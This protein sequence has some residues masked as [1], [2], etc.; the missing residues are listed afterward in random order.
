MKKIVLV[1][2]ALSIVWVSCNNTTTS[3]DSTSSSAATENGAAIAFEKNNFDFGKVAAG[4]KV[5][6]EFKFKNTGNAPLIIS[7]AQA[8]CGCTVP[9]YPKEPVAPGESGVIRVVFDSAGR[10]GMQNKIVSVTSNATP[11]L[12]EIYLTGEVTAK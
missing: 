9:E 1:L 2:I 8:S 5:T 4:A 6:H 10:Q 7:N 11:S 3:T 12:T